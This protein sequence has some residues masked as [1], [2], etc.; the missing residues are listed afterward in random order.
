MGE[1]ISKKMSVQDKNWF[2][3]LE[4]MLLSLCHEKLCLSLKLDWKMRFML[5]VLWG[6]PKFKCW[7]PTKQWGKDNTHPGTCVNLSSIPK[8][9][10]DD[11]GLVGSSCQ[12]ER[13]FPSHCRLVWT[14][15]DGGCWG[16]RESLRT[17]FYLMLD[18]ED[19]NVHAAHEAGH[20]Q[21]GR[22]AVI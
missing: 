12:M 17:I 4:T 6:F 14:C 22:V 16:G 21:G 1:K 2:H 15:L 18:Q 9:D 13:S 11:V 7:S 19:D 20:V 10:P 8:E 3:E 5:K